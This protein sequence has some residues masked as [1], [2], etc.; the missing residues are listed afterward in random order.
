METERSESSSSVP[1]EAP[2]MMLQVLDGAYTQV[3]NGFGLFP[4]AE[5]VAREYLTQNNN[6]ARKA[7]A[8]L[9]NW[10]MTKAATS[11][12]L[13]NLGG[14]ATLPISI[15]ANISSVLYL[16]LR[17]IAA[18]AIMG[19]HDIRSDKVRT[20]VY[21]TLLGSAAADV[22]KDAGIQLGQKLTV[23]AISRL[24]GLVARKMA[25]NVAAR[26][27]GKLGLSSARNFMKLVP[28]AGG[29]VAAATDAAATKAIGVVATKLFVGEESGEAGKSLDATLGAQTVGV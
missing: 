27:L 9:I 21:V 12:F 20:L 13:T 1:P 19:G 11:G 25:T 24:M 22:L 3:L 14:A 29:L 18:I 23:A 10:Q 26:L 6:D 8:D 4:S 5:A 16:Q 28:I 15:P 17:M 2:G 7:A